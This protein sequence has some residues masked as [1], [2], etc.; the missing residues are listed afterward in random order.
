[1]SKLRTFL[2]SYNYE[3]AQYSFEI[4]AYSLDEAKARLSRITFA[5]Y[6][7]ELMC[8]IPAVAGAGIFVRI[9]TWLKNLK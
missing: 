3:G 6:D 2:F 4:P 7:G 9:L 5:K 8:K 1:M